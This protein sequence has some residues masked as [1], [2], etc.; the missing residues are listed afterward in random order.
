M[1]WRIRMERP[2]LFGVAA[3]DPFAS[4][5]SLSEWFDG[6]DP[7]PAVGRHASSQSTR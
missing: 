7:A 6:L 4:T 2:Y 1:T 5:Y 3:V